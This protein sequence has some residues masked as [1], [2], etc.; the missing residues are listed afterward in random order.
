MSP[1]SQAGGSVARGVEEERQR[2]SVP[3]SRF[4][5]VLADPHTGG[6]LLSPHHHGGGLHWSGEWQ[7]AFGLHSLYEPY[8][9]VYGPVGLKVNHMCD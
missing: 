2:P 7:P 9:S 6:D 3:R 1:G 5:E 8:C 4:L